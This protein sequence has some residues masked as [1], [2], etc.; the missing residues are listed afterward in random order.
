MS[1]PN[2]HTEMGNPLFTHSVEPHDPVE[3]GEPIHALETT[4]LSRE[5]EQSNSWAAHQN[6]A[7]AQTLCAAINDEQP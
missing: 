6:K 1:S 5:P 7:D 2:P 3:V 4:A